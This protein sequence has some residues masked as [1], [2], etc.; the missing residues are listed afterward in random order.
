L[1]K[2]IH[3][4][5]RKSNAGRKPHDVT[6]IFK[7]LVLKALYNLSDGQTEF[8]LPDRASFQR[9]FGLSRE[10]TVPDA[11]T[12]WLFREQL[13]RHGLID[14]LIRRFDEQLWASG[15]MPKGCQIVDASLANV[16]KNSNTR[17]ENKQIKKGQTP[18]CRIA[19][20]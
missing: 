13:A 2:V 6:L 5:Q 4:E 3:Q 11:K 16:P 14:K 8:Q 17:D 7:L 12:L 10:A 20:N 19:L 18:E 9:F 1:P 15:L